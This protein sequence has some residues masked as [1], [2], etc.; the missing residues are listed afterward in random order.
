[1]KTISKENGE[2]WGGCGEIGNLDAEG[3]TIILKYALNVR[4]LVVRT[5]GNKNVEEKDIP[6]LFRINWA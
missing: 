5:P 4:T 1:M 6:Y 3:A 2:G